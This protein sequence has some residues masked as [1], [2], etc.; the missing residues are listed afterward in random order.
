MCRY[1]D[2]CDFD[3]DDLAVEPTEQEAELADLREQV[4]EILDVMREWTAQADAAEL[5]RCL[6]ELSH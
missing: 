3:P 1:S 2:G 6:A 4:T 5:R